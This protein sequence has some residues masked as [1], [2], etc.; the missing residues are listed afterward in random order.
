MAT[1]M[2]LTGF[3]NTYSVV[4]EY[5]N[6][7]LLMAIVIAITKQ[8]DEEPYLCISCLHVIISDTGDIEVIIT[9]RST[10]TVNIKQMAPEIMFD[11]YN[12]Q[13]QDNE[14][15]RLSYDKAK[16]W[17]VGIF[18]YMLLNVDPDFPEFVE[19][20]PCFIKETFTIDLSECGH[21]SNSAKKL[22]CHLV[23]PNVD[24]RLTC[25]ELAKF[26]HL[27]GPATTG[28]ATT[29]STTTESTTTGSATT[30]STTD[31]ARV[32]NFYEKLFGYIEEKKLDA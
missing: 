7:V 31:E 30:E 10:T 17:S 25:T 15:R 29:E 11:M 18:F 27:L 24:K 28:S 20:T 4:G 21:F 12:I 26:A 14:K 19:V 9:P 6:L 23:T 8:Q 5:S 32:I 13:R 2:T 16:A 1:K 22:I 3:W